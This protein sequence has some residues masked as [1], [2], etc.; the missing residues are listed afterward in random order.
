[1]EGARLFPI[2]DKMPLVSD[3]FR[4][5]CRARDGSFYSN[6][7]SGIMFDA[8]LH[9]RFADRAFRDDNRAGCVRLPPS[10]HIWNPM[11]RT[12]LGYNVLMFGFDSVSR[13]TFM[14]FLPKSYH[15]LIRELGSVVMKGRT[16]AAHRA[17]TRKRSSFQATILSAM[18]RRLPCC[19]FS[20]AKPSRSCPRRDAASRM[21]RPSIDSRGFGRNFEVRWK[22]ALVPLS[23]SIARGH[24][25]HITSIRER[26]KTDWP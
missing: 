22:S 6:I 12:H 7:H 1:M 3:F 10:R 23:P 15:Y 21:L 18:A 11:A 24:F 26:Q 19:R 2:V 14:R 4:A 9:R 20:L 13:M 16:C 17:R 5:D 8:G 25:P